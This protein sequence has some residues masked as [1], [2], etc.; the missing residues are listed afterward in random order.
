MWMEETLGR[1]IN[2]DR[3]AEALK[4]GAQTIAVACPFCLTMLDD[5]IKDAG[6]DQVAVRDVAEIIAA[7]LPAGLGARDQA[8][9][10]S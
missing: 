1:R 8:P 3:T 7:H 4:T 5:G 10:A 2:A 6:A 9:A